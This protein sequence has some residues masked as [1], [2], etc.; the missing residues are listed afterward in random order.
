MPSPLTSGAATIHMAAITANPDLGWAYYEGLADQGANPQGGNGGTY[1]AVAGGEKLYGFVVDFLPIR[2]QLKGA[3]VAFVFPG[4]RRLRRHRAGRDPLHRPEPG[5]G[6]GLRRLP[7]LRGRPEACR[8]PGLSA[9][10]SRRHA[11]GRL[12]GPRPIKLMDF[13]PAKALEQDQANK[14]KFDRDLRR[15]A[16]ATICRKPD[17]DPGRSEDPGRRPKRAPFIVAPGPGS[18]SSGMME[19]YCQHACDQHS[20]PKNPP[21][22]TAC[23]RLPLALL[24]AVGLAPEG[25]MTLAPLMETAASRSVQRALWNSLESSFLSAVLASLAGTA[26]ALVI[27]LTNVRAKGALVFLVLIPMMIPPH[28]TAIAW[29]QALGPASPVLQWLGLA[30]AP[31]SPHPVYTPGGL[32]ALLALQHMPIVFLVVRAALRAFPRE[33]E[34]CGKGQRRARAAPAHAHHAA[35]AGARPSRRFRARLRQRAWKFRHQRADRH[36][37]ALHH[38]AGADL[39]QACRLR[40]GRDRQCRLHLGDPRPRH[41]RPR[42]VQSLLQRGLRTALIGLPQQPLAIALKRMRGAVEARSVGFVA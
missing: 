21:S 34:R 8:Q 23:L 31:G 26:L 5:R 19:S 7:D 12:P 18:P 10:A 28:V 24:F 29:S 9:R 40:T 41:P 2:E 36:S 22:T 30:P 14:M 33:L 38:P 32:V 27:G 20:P 39:A 42:P 4:R 16:I 17:S 1:K 13:N 15:V 11:A 6:K 3:P 25:K 35:A 37:G